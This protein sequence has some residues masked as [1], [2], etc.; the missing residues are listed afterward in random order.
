VTKAIFVMIPLLFALNTTSTVFAADVLPQNLRGVWALEPADCSNDGAADFR[1]KVT[2]NEV[3]FA[4]SAW[5]ARRWKQSGSGWHGLA[6]VNE[7]GY[8]GHLPGLRSITL[9]L[10]SGKTL[11]ISLQGEPA[12]IYHRCLSSKAS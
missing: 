12:T 10:T 2:A 9:Q 4:A 8:A 3:V 7:E 11:K 5:A 1:V 6:R